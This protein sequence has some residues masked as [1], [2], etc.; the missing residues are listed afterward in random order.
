MLK[1]ILIEK[2]VEGVNAE[3]AEKKIIDGSNI[4][5]ISCVPDMCQPLHWE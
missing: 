5:G 3:R 1:Q 4:A 2:W